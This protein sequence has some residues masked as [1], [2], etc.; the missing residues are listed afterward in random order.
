MSLIE[1]VASGFEWIFGWDHEQCMTYAK[2]LVYGIILLI[3][4]VVGY[5]GF[6]W[7]RGWKKG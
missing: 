4:G 1:S 7:Y 5:K 6:R 2:A 3:L